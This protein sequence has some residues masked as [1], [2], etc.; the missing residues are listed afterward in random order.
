MV[1]N[2]NHSE[3]KYNDYG[4]D[5]TCEGTY[6]YIFTFEN[7]Q[8][9]KTYY[10]VTVD[11]NNEARIFDDAYQVQNIKTKTNREYRLMNQK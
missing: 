2:D 8:H 10:R 4:I 11:Q 1:N 3:N 6:Y 9:P 7:K 5:S